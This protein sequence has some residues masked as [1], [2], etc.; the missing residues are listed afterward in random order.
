MANTF[1]CLRYHVVFSTKHRER[2]IRP[3]L[4][5]RVWAYLGGITKQG[6]M[7]ALLVGG[8]EDHLH[9]LLGLPPTLALSG[10]IKQIN[11]GSSGWIREN[12]PG[13][14]GFGWQDGYAAFTVSRSQAP[15]VEEYIRGQREH[16]RVRTFQDEYRA[17]LDRHGIEYE[18][19]Y[20]WD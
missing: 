4:Q 17:L 18:E 15:G 16:H 11:G 14:R 5:E 8:V 6:G 2:W 9:M 10:A 13:C 7:K 19:R 1:T 3:E 12:L 20:L